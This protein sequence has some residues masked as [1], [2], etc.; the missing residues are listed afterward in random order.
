MKKKKAWFACLLLLFSA[1]AAF[2]CKKDKHK[3]ETVY[4]FTFHLADE[5]TGRQMYSA[6]A[7]SQIITKYLQ[8]TGCAFAEY[9]A[10]EVRDK[11]R[12]DNRD[13]LVFAVILLPNQKA[14]CVLD[15]I[16]TELNLAHAWYIREEHTYRELKKQLQ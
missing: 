12:V 5:N 6:E 2:T 15:A 1:L 14:R 16:K 3:K 11:K 4:K 8:S 10:Y 7:A 9:K 13:T